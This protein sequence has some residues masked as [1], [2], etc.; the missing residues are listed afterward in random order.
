MNK[1]TTLVKTGTVGGSAGALSIDNGHD[2]GTNK[3]SNIY[4]FHAVIFLFK[5]RRRGIMIKKKIVLKVFP[6]IPREFILFFFFRLC[7]NNMMHL[8]SLMHFVLI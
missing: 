2:R 3:S 5:R 1:H 7:F 4:T 8:S 6:F